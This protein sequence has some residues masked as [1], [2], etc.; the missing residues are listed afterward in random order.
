MLL[1]TFEKVLPRVKK[2]IV[3]SANGNIGLRL[4]EGGVTPLG[5]R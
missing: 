1:E 4:L 3:D 5:I 2:Y